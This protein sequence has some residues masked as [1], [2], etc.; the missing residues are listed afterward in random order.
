MHGIIKFQS[1]SVNKILNLIDSIFLY[2]F[3]RLLNV[4]GASAVRSGSEAGLAV[5]ADAVALIVE[6]RSD[7]ADLALATEGSLRV[8]ALPQRAQ[9]PTVVVTRHTFIIV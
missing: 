8:T 1:I 5:D 7:V 4:T 6:P 9:V 3:F 2:F